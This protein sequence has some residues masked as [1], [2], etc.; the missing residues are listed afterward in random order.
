MSEKF[1]GKYRIP[2][3]RLQN[4]DYGWKAIYFVTI[5]TQNREHYFGD[6][7]DGEMQLSEIGKMVE[8]EW[9]K[10]FEMRTDMNLHKD[11]YVV[12]PNHFHGIIIIGEN[13]YNTERGSEYGMERGMEYGMER[14][15]QRGMEYWTQRGSQRG[16][17]YGTQRGTQRRDAM[18]CVST[19]TPTTPTTPTNANVPK[20][21][22]GPQSKNLASIIRGF[23][24]AVTINARKIHADFSWQSSYHDHIIRNDGSFQRIRNYIC[25]NP[26]K[27]TDD[28]FYNIP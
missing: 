23:K 4:W 3:T 18:H 1:Q 28:K 25:E 11:K 16:M 19:T 15:S 8:P 10:T 22:F 7:V 27:W 5:C 12:M 2:S 6:V 14:G 21:K 24:S 20:N 13:E 17:E 9:L 26:A